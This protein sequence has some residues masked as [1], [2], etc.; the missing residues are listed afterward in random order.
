MLNHRTYATTRPFHSQSVEATVPGDGSASLPETDRTR[1]SS[2]ISVSTRYTRD[3]RISGVGAV[4][5]SRTVTTAEVE[6]RVGICERFGLERGWLEHV[7]GVRTRRWA[8]PETL[9]SELAVAAARQALEAADVDPGLIDVVL[10]TGITRDFYE[11]ATANVVADGVGAHHA[12]ALDLGN[13]CNGLLDGLDVANLMIRAGHARRVLVAT[14][15][16]ASVSINWKPTSRE[17]LMRS[18]AG[19]LLSDGGGAFVVEATDDPERG[20]RERTFLADPSK[21]RLALGGRSHPAEP[22]PRC[23]GVVDPRFSCDGVRLFSAVFALVPAAL[24]EVMTRTGWTYS[25]LDVAFCHEASGRYAET[26]L[27]RLPEGRTIATK[28]WSTVERLGNTTTLSIPAAM[29]EAQAAGAL[30]PGA[31]VLV[32]SSCAGISVAALTL[33]W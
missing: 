7:S 4:L 19:L 2:G 11:P 9:P 5:P 27:A 12:R 14:G 33:V 29:V 24:E 8:D 25:E 28:L 18:I 16:R 6:E 20:L 13:A 21:W 26:G 10:F 30:A 31:K 22:C 1:R 3:A 17:E 23:D 32:L 15:E